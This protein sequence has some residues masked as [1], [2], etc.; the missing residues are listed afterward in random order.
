MR[1]WIIVVIVVGGLAFW[2]GRQSIPELRDAF[3]PPTPHERYARRLEEAGLMDAALGRL[4]LRASE[5]ALVEAPAVEAPFRETGYLDPSRPEAV[6]YRFEARAGERLRFHVELTPATNAQLFLDVFRSRSD[7]ARPPDRVA[8]AE[9]DGRSVE[10]EPGRDGEYVVRLQPEL[11]RGG[12]YT[13][14]VTAEPTLAFPV[15]GAGVANVRS[16]FGDPRDSGTRD[17][18]GIDIFAARGTP[19]VAATAGRVS[20]RTT[21]I[22]GR[23][24]WLRDERRGQS[25]YYAHLETQ[26]V[27][28]GARVRPGDTLGLV[29]N[30]GNARNTPP[31]LHFGVYRRGQGPL[32]P[33]PF[34]RPHPST[35]PAPALA[36]SASGGTRRIAAS[37]ASLRAG[38]NVDAALIGELDRHAPLRVAAVVGDWLRV[39]LPDGRR[40][41]VAARLTEPASPLRAVELER[42]APLRAGPASDSPEVTRADAGD[43]VDVLG[44]LG[45]QLYVQAGDLDAW[46]I[47]GPDDA[48]SLDRRGRNAGQ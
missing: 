48:A 24:V 25:V 16:F 4:W 9:V 40:G 35:P 14:T 42:P 20:V 17:H 23:V 36:G 3:S 41:F 11:L 28:G 37:T 26:L 13:L 47:E 45:N 44:R 38:P 1:V 27:E 5:R 15:A 21:P 19:V 33:L 7:T 10:I 34:V 22:G 46:L 29:G 39:E 30:S 18:H 31:H 43:R 32:D 2:L 12:R 8:S 6:A